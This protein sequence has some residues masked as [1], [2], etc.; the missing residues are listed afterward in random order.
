MDMHRQLA[1]DKQT[2]TRTLLN[3][4]KAFLRVKKLLP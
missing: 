4:V 3:G 2:E 1:R